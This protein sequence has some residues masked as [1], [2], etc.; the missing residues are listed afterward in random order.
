MSLIANQ[1]KHWQIKA[2]NFTTDQ[3]NYGYR[4]IDAYRNVL[5]HIMREKIAA[6]TFRV[7]AKTNL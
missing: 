1:T 7:T 4:N 6:E 3:R 5:H 2:V